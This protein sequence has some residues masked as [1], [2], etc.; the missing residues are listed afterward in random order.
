MAD[1]LNEHE[2]RKYLAAFADG[3]LDVEQNLRVLE[4]M[5]INPQATRRVMHQQQLRQAVDRAIRDSTP[6]TP[7]DLRR[8]IEQLTS[9]NPAKSAAGIGE[10]QKSRP[11]K[12]LP[13][14]TPSGSSGVWTHFTRWTPLAAA[15]MFF[16][17]AL[18]VLNLAKHPEEPVPG[19]QY[20]MFVNR[21]N[22]CSRTIEKL[23]RMDQFPQNIE[24]LPVA[25][26]GFLGEQPTPGL[27]LSALGYEFQAVGECN[28][29]GDKS[30]H[31]IYRA[32]GD[33]SGSDTLSLWVRR[34][35][36]SPRVD[37]DRLYVVTDAGTTEPL[38]VWRQGA[39]I[40][41]LVGRSLGRVE[42]AANRLRVSG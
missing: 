13:L 18:V 19:A 30:V 15:A 28:V 8:T 6:Q 21:H 5:A 40:Y 14:P 42:S 35:S 23:S 39:M 27:D 38:L 1:S 2:S 17:S 16:V 26:G 37:P 9:Q 25:L 34:Y 36:G 29:P 31:L 24:A 33:N 41:Y 10:D 7:E 11:T 22:S 4:Q 12:P 32:R 3:E 20:A